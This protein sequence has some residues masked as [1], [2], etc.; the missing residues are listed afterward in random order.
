MGEEPAYVEFVFRVHADGRRERSAC[1]YVRRPDGTVVPA[2]G[3]LNGA[4]GEFAAEAVE[5]VVRLRRVAIDERAAPQRPRRG[6]R[7]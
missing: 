4:V 6:G 5:E 2:A 7:R 1:V 3:R